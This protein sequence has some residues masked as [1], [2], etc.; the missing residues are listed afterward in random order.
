MLNKASQRDAINAPV[1][2][3][4]SDKNLNKELYEINKQ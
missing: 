1:L 3:G 2:A 4:V